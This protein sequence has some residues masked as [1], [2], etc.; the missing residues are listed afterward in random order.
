MAML[1]HCTKPQGQAMMSAAFPT[2]SAAIMK[3]SWRALPT[4]VEQI[5]AVCEPARFI[6]PP[7]ANEA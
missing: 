4:A 3:E 7:P 6:A 2:P 1:L 5:Y